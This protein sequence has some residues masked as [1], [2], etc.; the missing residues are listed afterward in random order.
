MFVNSYSLNPTEER[1]KESEK[2]KGTNYITSSKTG[3]LPPTR[4]VFPP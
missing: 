2:K 3:T 1:V 4:P